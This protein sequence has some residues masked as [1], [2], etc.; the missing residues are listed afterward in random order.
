MSTK[1]KDDIELYK[2]SHR[3]KFVFLI[4]PDS[5]T[6]S[7]FGLSLVFL[8]KVIAIIYS[9]RALTTTFHSF[10]N[11][12]LKM[13][14][15]DLFFNYLCIVTALLQYIAIYTKSYIISY[16]IYLVYFSHFLLKAWM[17]SFILY[18]KLTLG[19][20][21]FNTFLGVSLGL[22]FGTLINLISTWIIFSYFVYCYNYN[23]LNKNK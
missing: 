9:F 12:N 16:S 3:F 22:S 14:N 21:M 6:K 20:M 18:K 4:T 19:K 15:I 10:S 11:P 17:S 8:L 2:N 7:H 1:K 23:H 5:V 13:D